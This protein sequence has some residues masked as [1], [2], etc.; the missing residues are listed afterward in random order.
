MSFEIILSDRMKK[1]LKKLKQKDRVRFTILIKKIKQIAESD[2]KTINHYKNLKNDLSEYKRVHVDTSF[3][4]LFRV[5]K[6]E[7]KILF[8]RL[9]H[10][11]NVY[12]DK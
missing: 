2:E 9:R 12:R 11:D 5:F 10:H 7:K 4:L 1:I 8:A 6:K 3:V